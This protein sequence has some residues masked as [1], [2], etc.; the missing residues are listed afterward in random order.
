[1]PSSLYRLVLLVAFT[2]RSIGPGCPLLRHLGLHASPWHNVPSD[3][4]WAGPLPHFGAS[5]WAWGPLRFPGAGHS[6]PLMLGLG[7]A[8][9]QVSLDTRHCTPF[10]LSAPSQFLLTLASGAAPGCSTGTAPMQLY[11]TRALRQ[12]A[13]H[14]GTTPTKAQHPF[15]V[16]GTALLLHHPGKAPNHASVEHWIRSG[17]ACAHLGFT[18]ARAPHTSLRQGPLCLPHNSRCSFGETDINTPTERLPQ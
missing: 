4:T 3:L 16:L 1:M 2:A 8:P 12:L 13:W 17:F 7:T 9:T 15:K 14:P 11:L 10:I 18:R 5:T 6:A